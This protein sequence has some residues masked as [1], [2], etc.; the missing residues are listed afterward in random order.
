M[1]AA[2]KVGR[3]EAG[4]AGSEAW[5]RLEDYRRV[6]EAIRFLEERAAEQ[7][8]LG[9]VARHVGLSP[10]HFQRLFKRWAGVSPK[11]FLQYLTLEHAKRLLAASESLLET[12]WEVG[13]SSPGRLHDL[14]VAAEA[15]TP[16]E[17]KRRG[18]GLTLRWGVHPSPF[19]RCLLAATARGICH[20]SFL[21][22]GSAEEPAA[23][24][25]RRFRRSDLRPDPVATGRLVER[26]FRSEPGG[27]EDPPL[28][29]HLRGTNFQLQVWKALLALPEGCAVTY[30]DLA[31]HLGRPGGARAVGAAV[32][33]N[34]VAYVIPCHRVLRRGGELGGYRWGTSRKKALL[35]W[36]AARLEA[37]PA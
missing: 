2:M 34:P 14:F 30:G 13:L 17:F 18:E 8:D 21:A 22:P 12:T 26:I 24:L 10:H 19:G 33:A 28:T 7:P 36:E 5:W 4:Q 32:G 1:N 6:E 15:V 25:R 37:S 9:A 27:A 3:N 20:L 23:E 29:L 35:G 16:G 31:R 11:R